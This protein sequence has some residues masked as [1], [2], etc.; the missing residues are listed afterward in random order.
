M[1]EE[2]PVVQIHIRNA[3][4]DDK[5]IEAIKMIV[6]YSHS[7]TSDANLEASFSVEMHPES[8]TSGP[9]HEVGHGGDKNDIL[10]ELRDH[11]ATREGFVKDREKRI[12]RR[13]AD[14]FD[15]SSKP[16]DEVNKLTSKLTPRVSRAHVGLFNACAD[17]FP[18]KRAALERAV[19][20]LALET[21]VN[22]DL[23]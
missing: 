16:T 23:E 17:E 1:S 11:L 4:A 18:N 14:L 20:L 5:L 15:P 7:Q 2:A 13:K 10:K 6:E 3:A 8:P 12:Y 9:P 22:V 19:E 21:G